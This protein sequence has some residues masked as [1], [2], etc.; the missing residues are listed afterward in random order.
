MK[1]VH[2]RVSGTTGDAETEVMGA[3]SIFHAVQVSSPDLYQLS[4]EEI[5]MVPIQKLVSSGAYSSKHMDTSTS[6]LY[7]FR[8]DLV[9]S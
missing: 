3:P 4:A 8:Y 2:S 9:T 5:Q 1:A 7:C 6:S